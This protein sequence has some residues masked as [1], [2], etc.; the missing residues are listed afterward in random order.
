MLVIPVK[1]CPFYMSSNVGVK[2]LIIKPLK[3]SLAAVM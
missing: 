2:M 3:K 1:L